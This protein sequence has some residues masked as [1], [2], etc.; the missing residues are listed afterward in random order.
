LNLS[1][2]FLFQIQAGSN[3]RRFGLF[4]RFGFDFLEGG[5][6][7]LEGCRFVSRGGGGAG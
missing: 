6:R 1:T 2:E 3:N 5:R 4:W 7:N